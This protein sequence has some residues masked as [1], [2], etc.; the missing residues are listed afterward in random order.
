MKFD[1]TTLAFIQSL[2]FVTQVIVLFIQYRVNRTFRGIKW[3]VLGSALMA[4]GVIFMPLVTVKSLEILARFANPLVVLGQIFLYIGIIKFLDMKENKWILISIFTVFIFSYYYYMFFSNSISARTVVVNATEA[5]I[6]IKAAYQLFSKKPKHISGSANFTAAIFL[7]FGSFLTMRAF[8]TLL[9]PPMH[10][11]SDQAM[12]FTAAFIVPNIASTLWTFG[13]I[14]MHNQRL[15]AENLV[16]KEKVQQL[17]Q[18]LEVERNTAQLNSLTDSLTGLANR[19]YFDEALKIEFNRSKRSGFILSLIMLDIDYFKGFNDSYGHL[20][21]DDCLR[22][23]GNVLKTIVKR[24]SDIVARYGGEE[25]VVLLPETDE[26]GA[27][28]L[29][30]GI[31]KAIEELAIPNSDSQISE[32]VTVSFGIVTLDTTRLALPEQV[33]ALA[34]EA[35]YNAKKSGRN[36]IEVAT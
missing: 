17:I 23:I 25:F 7:T 30:E 19:R 12:I 28:A 2:T 20:A 9:L 1:I 33:V 26:N 21:G 14:I 15:D 29:A 27:R 18:Q 32:F 3:W 10:A 24:V 8:L 13:F 4:L 22:Q 31:Q 6:T 36:R 5:T 16:E 34:D 35:L 11:Y